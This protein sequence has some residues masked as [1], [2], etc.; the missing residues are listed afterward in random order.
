M[1]NT[2]DGFLDNIAAVV[3]TNSKTMQQVV[4]VVATLT[5]TNK[6]QT[7]TIASQ[8]KTIATLGLGLTKQSAT[9]KKF[10]TLTGTMWD[11]HPGHETGDS[12]YCWA[13]GYKLRKGHTGATCKAREYLD[14]N[15]RRKA[16]R[17][18]NMD[19][20]QKNKGFDD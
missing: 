2:M 14:H 20:S 3:T 18:N 16:T 9:S 13:H 1:S 8:Q 19:G 5:K 6:Q 7:A 15:N 12:A 10:Q 17:S 11:I 4:V